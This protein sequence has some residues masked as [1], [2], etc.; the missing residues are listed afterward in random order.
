[1]SCVIFITRWFLPL[2]ALIAR[3][4]PEVDPHVLIPAGLD[5]L[6][7][8]CEEYIAVGF[9]KLVLVPVHEPP[10]WEAELAAGAE[11][12]LDLQT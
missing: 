9:S 12:V 10:D 2:A 8:R 1:M 7:A 4:N 6:R 5:R 3:R 11:A